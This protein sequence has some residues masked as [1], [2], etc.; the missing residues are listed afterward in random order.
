M[1]VM[2]TQHYRLP[3]QNAK[4]RI[5]SRYYLL[6]KSKQVKVLKA[7]YQGR[8]YVVCVIPY[9][10]WRNP[11][12]RTYTFVFEQKHGRIGSS[13]TNLNVGCQSCDAPWVSDG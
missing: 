10:L 7:L 4:T 3:V 13:E 6:I 5:G 12:L 2:E 9:R 11:L 8:N 1:F